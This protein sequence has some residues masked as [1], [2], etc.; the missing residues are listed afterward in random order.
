METHEQTNRRLEEEYKEIWLPNLLTKG[1]PDM[2]KIKNEIMDLTFVLD[3][4]GKVYC[5]ITGNKLSY[6]NYFA[7]TVISVYQDEISKSYDEGYADCKEDN[8]I[9]S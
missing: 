9:K 1:K 3:Q 5:E 6:P 7:D 8:N 4:V 2:K